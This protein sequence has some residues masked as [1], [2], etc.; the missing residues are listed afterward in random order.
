MLTS[1]HGYWGLS[2]P[3]FSCRWSGGI[4]LTFFSL[5]SDKVLHQQSSEK[6]VRLW[7]LV[8]QSWHNPRL[9]FPPT[10]LPLS[11]TAWGQSGNPVSDVLDKEPGVPVT[12]AD[13][14]TFSSHP[15]A[16]LP[17]LCRDWR[18]L[19]ER[20]G[21]CQLGWCGEKH[22][23]SRYVWGDRMVGH[24]ELLESD[25]LASNSLTS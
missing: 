8:L 11:H 23:S 4:G 9:H 17:F 3:S 21:Q 15:W 14:L 18:G 5:L 16:P 19:W 24:S 2:V 6:Q 7:R 20:K 12:I 10:C 1:S 22:I 25:C 13:L